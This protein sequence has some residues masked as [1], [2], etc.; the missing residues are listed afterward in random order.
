MIILIDQQE[1]KPLEFSTKLDWLDGT[2]LCHLKTGDYMV[3]FT[4]GHVPP[5]CIERKSKADL[6]GTLGRGMG[7]FSREIERALDNKYK[8][9]LFIECSQ[10]ECYKPCTYRKGGKTRTVKM[11]PATIIKTLNTLETKYGV[12]HKFYN[13]REEMAQAVYNKF[14]A[15]GALYLK[16]KKKSRRR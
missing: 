8:F 1:K 10:S 13:N 2:E 7:R 9:F 4:D 14:Y 15:E 3:R 12:V 6:Y 5:V 16:D 11:K